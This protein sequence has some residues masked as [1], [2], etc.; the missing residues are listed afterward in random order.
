MLIVQ[1][2]FTEYNYFNYCIAT[3][4][5]PSKS[6]IQHHKGRFGGHKKFGTSCQLQVANV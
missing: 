3:L 5:Q 2:W 4:R 6:C 1:Q